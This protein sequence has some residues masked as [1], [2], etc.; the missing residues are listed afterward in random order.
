M[1][2]ILAMMLSVALAKL[3]VM[4]PYELQSQF[5]GQNNSIPYSVANFGYTMRK[6]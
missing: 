1:I 6:I 3:R 5:L 4:S 2:T